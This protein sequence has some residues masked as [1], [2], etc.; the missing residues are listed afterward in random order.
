MKIKVEIDCSP[1]EARKFLGLPDLEPMQ[2]SLLKQIQAQIASAVPKMSAE[3]LVK[4][5]VSLGQQGYEEFQRLLRE[6][7]GGARKRGRE[8]Q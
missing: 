8:G 3:Q 2:M 1:Q 5:W 4:S 6:A 7:A